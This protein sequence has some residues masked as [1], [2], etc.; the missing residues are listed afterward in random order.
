VVEAQAGS[1][2]DR[3]AASRAILGAFATFDRSP[4][5][6]SRRT[7]EPR[8][9][10]AMLG[11]VLQQVRTAVS[12]PVR[13]TLGATRYTVSRRQL[14]R[15]LKLPADGSRTLGIGGPGANAY[16][17][18]LQREVNTPAKN[19][20]FVPVAGGR[21]LIKPSESARALDVPRTAERLLAA[22]LRPTRRV[23]PAV[24]GRREPAR[25]TEDAR[26]M[27]VTGLV[28]SYTTIYTGDPNRVHTVR[29]V[30]NL[31]GRRV[32]ATRPKASSRPR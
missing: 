30:A 10:A 17:L 3:R 5:V 15:L 16:F 20:E 14:A 29:L 25:T 13:L 1:V 31:P 18:A 28:S 23:A 4:V 24:V 22:A 27:G 12:R 32:S 2:L 7:E 26:K 19:A 8:V 9:T 6:L 11:P 21:V